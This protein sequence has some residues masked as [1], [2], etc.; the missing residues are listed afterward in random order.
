MIAF[1]VG[2]SRFIMVCSASI[3]YFNRDTMSTRNPILTSLK[4]L[5]IYHMGSVAFGA[6]LLAI[7][8]VIQIIAEYVSVGL[9]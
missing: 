9:G 6:L 5:S 1:I 8:W 7:V 4:W 2:C 3:W